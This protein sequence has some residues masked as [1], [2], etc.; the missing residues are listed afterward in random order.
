[1]MAIDVIMACYA[2]VGGYCL[3]K[4]A[5]FVYQNRT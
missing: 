4:V 5:R 1:M 2:V 3:G